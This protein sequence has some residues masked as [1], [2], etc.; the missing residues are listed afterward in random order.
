MS[1]KT[2]NLALVGFGN[3]GRAFVGLLRTKHN[4]LRDQYAIDFRITG[5]ASRRLG[6]LAKPN[7]FDLDRL[8]EHGLTT[9]ETS[10]SSETPETSQRS[11]RDWLKVSSADVLFE[12][13]PLNRHTGEPASEHIRAALEH[14]AHAISA[15]KGPVVFHLD[16]LSQL[17]N[18]RGKRFLF[19][20]SVMDGTPIFNMFRHCLPAIDLRGFR[21]VL[22]STTNVILSGMERGMPFEEALRQAQQIGV[23]ESDPSDDI[24]G[25]DAAV[26]TVALANVL[27]GARLTP[28]DVER[29]GIAHLTGEQ[30]RVARRE[31][32]AYKLVCR[33][34]RRHGRV[35]AS[36]RPELL[37]LTD[38]LAL[39]DGTSSIV[40]FETDMFPGLALTED[41]AGLEATAYGMFS[42]FIEAVESDRAVSR[43]A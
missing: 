27:M 39:V 20:S 29:E 8:C 35:V 32:K 5:I 25:W 36:V 38:A 16:E 23:A 21:G 13:T 28:A 34:M 37:P 17:A 4:I 18:S 9:S 14:G 22:N 3:V 19:E 24:E 7:G 43:P 41:H 31:G 1:K 10:D 26:K 2:Y 6:W 33:A 30:V 40:Y 42:D 15:N 11:I 12:A